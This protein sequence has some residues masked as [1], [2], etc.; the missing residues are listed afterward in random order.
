[1]GMIPPPPMA[2]KREDDDIPH[3]TDPDEDPIIHRRIMH[4]FG[5]SRTSRP[6]LG[7][8]SSPRDDETTA[9]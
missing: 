4:G 3:A 1:M 6:R 5:P 2:V 7:G 8:S 9:L